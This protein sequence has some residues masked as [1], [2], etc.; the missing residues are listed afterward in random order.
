M[1]SGWYNRLIP[2]SLCQK[3][4]YFGKGTVCVFHTHYAMLQG[5]WD[6]TSRENLSLQKYH[7]LTHPKL[8]KA[9]KLP[10]VFSHL[11]FNLTRPIFLHVLNLELQIRSTH[12]SLTTTRSWSKRQWELLWNENLEL[13]KSYIKPNSIRNAK[14]CK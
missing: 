6:S 8:D 3:F 14:S 11:F 9:H 12:I 7:K 10:H 4:S 5:L 2:T 13:K 1:K